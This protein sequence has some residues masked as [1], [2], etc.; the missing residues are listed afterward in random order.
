[1]PGPAGD[2]NDDLDDEHDEHD[3]EHDDVESLGSPPHPLDRVWRHPSELPAV[4]PRPRVSAPKRDVGHFWVSLA[5]AGAG[6]VATVVILAAFGVFDNGTTQAPR[7]QQIIKEDAAVAKLA[8]DIAPSIVAVSA[9]APAGAR[10]GSGVCFR[11]SGD[12]LTSDRLVRDATRVTV[13]IN[14]G[15]V[16]Q[17]KVV[18]HDPATDLALL[19][20]TS[21][22]QAAPVAESPLH[23]GDSVL[24]VGAATGTGETPWIGEGIV[25]ST[26]GVVA[27]LGGPWMDGLVATDAKAGRSGSGGALLDRQ[28]AVAAIVVTPIDGDDANYAVPI[29]A[30]TDIAEELGT[31]GVAA[32]GW[33][34]VRGADVN[35]A[36]MVTTMQAHGP[37]DQAGIHRGDVVVAVGGRAVDTMGEVTA[38]VR[39]YKPN[40]TVAI[41]VRRANALVD[42]N[43]KMGSAAMNVGWPGA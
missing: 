24:A 35:G 29:D 25:S 20:V 8:A 16:R 43:V 33:L 15:T 10:H 27:Q 7:A 17:A 31:R 6:A 14:D 13:T 9:I 34:G 30:A 5:A 2:E 28:G 38:A 3:D 37:A 40:A 32:H 21:G 36:P 19:R 11:R 4:P 26:D 23:A 18:G 1:M 22:L 12:I 41:K 39:W 42:V